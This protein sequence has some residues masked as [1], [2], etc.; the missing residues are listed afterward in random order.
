MTHL[1][2][3]TYNGGKPHSV[4][5]TLTCRPDVDPPVTI[6]DLL[7]HMANALGEGP[8]VA[9]LGGYEPRRDWHV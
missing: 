4:A 7:W 2:S 9:R 1:A 6:L 8:T 5:V 3:G